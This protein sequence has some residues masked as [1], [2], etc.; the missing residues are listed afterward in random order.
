ML[1]IQTILQ[2]N[3][4]TADVTSDYWVN[5]KV[6]LIAGLDENQQKVGHISSL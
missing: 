6:I 2:K 1:K 3:L 5:E 4:Q